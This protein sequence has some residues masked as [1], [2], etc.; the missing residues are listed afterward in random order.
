MG[1]TVPLPNDAGKVFDEMPQ[2]ELAAK[3]SKSD[4]GGS[5]VQGVKNTWAS[6]AK[7]VGTLSTKGMKLGL[8]HQ[9][10]ERVLLWL[11]FRGKRS[12][13]CR[14]FGIIQLWCILLERSL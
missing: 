12:I 3:G 5:E 2:S 13:G 10:S 7:K 9:K 6:V 4:G 11:K 8:L 1:V 14:K